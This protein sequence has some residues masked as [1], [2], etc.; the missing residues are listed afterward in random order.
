MEWK[1]FDTNKPPRPGNYWFCSV[2]CRSRHVR[3]GVLHFSGGR[4]WQLQ[5]HGMAEDG[6]PYAMDLRCVTHY[7]EISAPQPPEVVR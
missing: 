5:I 6:E 2:F 4:K 7:A 3:L 1:K